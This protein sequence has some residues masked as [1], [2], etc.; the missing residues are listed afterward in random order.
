MNTLPYVGQHQCL[1]YAALAG[2]VAV[3]L[4]LVI[5]DGVLPAY[6]QGVFRLA[7]DFCDDIVS[8][9][10]NEIS[11]REAPYGSQVAEIF[12]VTT[13]FQSLIAG[14]PGIHTGLST[15]EDVDDI[16]HLLEFL[17]SDEAHPRAYPNERI[18]AVQAFFLALWGAVEQECIKEG[19]STDLNFATFHESSLTLQ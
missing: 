7:A 15:Y 12:E 1:R 8:G 18:H 4:D 3:G 11:E 17:A 5:N 16:A 9:A 6:Y 13:W 14:H 19:V 2:Q 10:Y